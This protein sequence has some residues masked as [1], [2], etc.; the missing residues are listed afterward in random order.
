MSHLSE[1]TARRF[2]VPEEAVG[3]TRIVIS[4]RSEVLIENSQGIAGYTENLVLV[5]FP[6][7]C[8]GIHGKSLAIRCLSREVIAVSGI[9]DCVNLRE[10]RC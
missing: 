4:G 3:G 5:K 8:I 10:G 9:I 7:D 6:P 1:W 2:G